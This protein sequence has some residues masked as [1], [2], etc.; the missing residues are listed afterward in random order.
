M[1]DIDCEKGPLSEL[2]L[3]LDEKGKIETIFIR[4]R[5]ADDR[6]KERCTQPPRSTPKK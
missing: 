4:P 5:A 3:G 2:Q 1:L 6:P